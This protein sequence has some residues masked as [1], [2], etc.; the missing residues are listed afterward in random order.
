[1]RPEIAG[2]SQSPKFGDENR[3]RE[4][5][6]DIAEPVGKACKANGNKPAHCFR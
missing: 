2:L 5:H 6:D 1:M 4:P 3:D